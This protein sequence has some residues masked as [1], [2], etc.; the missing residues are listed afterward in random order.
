VNSIKQAHEF[1]LNETMKL[2]ALLMFITDVH[3]LGL[4]VS[5]GLN[6]T[7]SFYWDLNDQTRAWTKRVLPK[8]PNNYPNM[9]HAGCYSGALHYM[10]AVAAMGAAEAKK[11]GVATVNQMKKMPVED[12]C[13]GK[14]TIREDGRH[15]V[16]AYLFQVKKPSESKGPWDYFNLVAT[17]PADEAFRPLAEGHCAFVKA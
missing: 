15:L 7:E 8:T 3:A 12:E 16:P 11:D 5:A 17:T 1:G 4:E 14:T 10:K 13:F 6:L 2:A 9:D